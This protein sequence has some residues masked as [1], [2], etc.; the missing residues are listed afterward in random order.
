MGSVGCRLCFEAVSFIQRYLHIIFQPMLKSS[1]NIS[2]I[3]FTMVYFLPSTEPW[4]NKMFPNIFCKPLTLPSPR[5]ES[6]TYPR[7]GLWTSTL[8][9]YLQSCHQILY[10]IVSLHCCLFQ[11]LSYGS[12]CL[13]AFQTFLLCFKVLQNASWLV[14]THLATC[15][16]SMYHQIPFIS[17]TSFII[18]V[19]PNSTTIM[20]HFQ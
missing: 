8:N 2:T 17:L 4:R 14:L 16:R 9:P 1:E 13:H 12:G 7:Q 18:R 10:C 15:T 11:P 20:L 3:P 6:I 19:N 5:F